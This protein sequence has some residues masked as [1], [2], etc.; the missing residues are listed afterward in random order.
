MQGALRWLF[1]SMSLVLPAFA[2]C[3]SPGAET[4]AA[5][6]GG[7]EA[8]APVMIPDVIAGI[9]LLANVPFSGGNDLAFEGQY[10][11]VSTHGNGMHVIDISDPTNPVEV[12]VVECS[13][14]DIDVIQLE[15]RRIV[16]IASQSD[17]GCPESSPRGG[18]RLVDVTKPAEP[19]VLAQ[20]PLEFGAH[21]LTP[22]GDTGLIY[23][24]AY[25]L[26][27]PL[28]YHRS[29]I[30]DITN[31]DD[32]KLAGAFPFPA[33]SLSHGCHDILAEPHRDRAICAGITETMIWDTT[34]PLS[35]K[36]VSTIRNPGISI[37]HSAATARD[38]TLLILGDE[39]GGA[40]APACNPSG[41]GPTGAL[42]F[43]DITNIADPQVL[44]FLPPPPGGPGKVCTAHNFNVIEGR[45]AM[46]AGFYSGGTV[47]VDFSNPASPKMLQQQA[48][49]DGSAWAAY[50]YNGYVYT[51]DG[52][53]GLDVYMLV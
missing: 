11:Y 48:P 49:A 51:G 22:Y 4:D 21:T 43:Y 38:G 7:D 12:S 18:I 10:A 2:G 23:V 53:R 33:T 16:V 32:P 25:D 27:N 8:S 26:T 20:V 13:G 50:Y 17:D 15:T 9:E 35:P 37:H 44:G 19:A 31:P 1:I 30:V 36:V 42:W 34:D 14:K 39:Y 41:Q 24:S 47:L 52:G 5:T 3:I 45:D 40:L 46:V 28:K 29:D 6:S